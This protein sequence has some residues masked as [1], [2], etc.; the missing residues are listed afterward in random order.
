MHAGQQPGDRFDDD[1]RGGLPARE[2]EVAD[3]ELAVAQVIGDPLVDTFVAAADQREA[4][5]ARE[6]RGQ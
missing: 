4:G 2:H 3:R 1:E 5:T 6:L